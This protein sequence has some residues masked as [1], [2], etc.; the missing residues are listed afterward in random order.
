MENDL[1]QQ[2]IIDLGPDVVDAIEVFLYRNLSAIISPDPSIILT[3]AFR[4]A[5]QTAL[6]DVGIRHNIGL[7]DDLKDVLDIFITNNAG[8]ITISTTP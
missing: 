3:P 5:L 8:S 7:P 6:N 4:A 1:L 2:S